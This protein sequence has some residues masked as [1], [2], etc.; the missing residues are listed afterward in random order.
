MTRLRYL[1]QMMVTAKRL[2]LCLFAV[3]QAYEPIRC[4]KR[5]M[6]LPFVVYLNKHDITVLDLYKLLTN[7]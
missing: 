2:Y 6:Q 7:C 3:V 1:T 4:H 5:L